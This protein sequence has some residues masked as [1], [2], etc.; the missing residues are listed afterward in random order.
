LT[1]AQITGN[2]KYM[3]I[4]LTISVLLN[5]W[6]QFNLEIFDAYVD[7]KYCNNSGIWSMGWSSYGLEV[8]GHFITPLNINYLDV[9]NRS[10]NTL[11]CM[12]GFV[13]PGELK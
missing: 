5:I 7:Y 10:S 9:E 1:Y 4:A 2:I 3:K 6:F 12:N 8:F 11:E 13:I